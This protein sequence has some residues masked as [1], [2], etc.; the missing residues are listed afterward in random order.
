MAMNA[1]SIITL[2]AM[3]AR[4]L[5]RNELQHLQ[6]RLGG[7]VLVSVRAL[8]LRVAAAAEDQVVLVAHLQ[9]LDAR[10]VVAVVVRGDRV[11]ALAEFVAADYRRG[12]AWSTCVQC[13]RG[14]R[15]VWQLRSFL[16]GG[17][18]GDA[19]NAGLGRVA[20]GGDGAATEMRW[21]CWGKCIQSML[22]PVHLRYHYCVRW[23]EDTA[24]SAQRLYLE[25]RAV[26][27]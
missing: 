22:S 18:E 26:A 12:G 20:R 11:D 10:D 13:R 9:L 2:R 23:R 4:R 19:A 5:A 14:C 8:G 25:S 7:F 15:F 16:G 3:A 21:D 1:L 6:F 24:G 17:R 27:Q